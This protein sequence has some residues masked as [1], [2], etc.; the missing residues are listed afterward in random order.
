MKP[1]PAAAQAAASVSAIIS[2]WSRP[3][4]WQGPAISVSG[5]RFETPTSPI[6]TVLCSVMPLSTRPSDSRP[7][8]RCKAAWRRQG[9]RPRVPAHGRR[10]GA[11]TGGAERGDRRLPALRRRVRRHR[12]RRTRRGRCRGC[13]TRRS[14]SAGRR[15]GRGC[16][17]SG[18]RST[19]P[20]ATGCA[21]GWGWTARRSTTGGGSRCCRWRS[22]FR[23]TT[24]KAPTCRRRRSAP[25]PGG[26]GRWRRCRGVRLTLLIGGHAQRWHLGR[27]GRSP[28]RCGDWRDFGPDVIPLPHPVL[29]QHRLAEAQSVVRGGAGAGA[30]AAGRG[31]CWTA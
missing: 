13:R 29:A 25:A 4:S 1:A 26:R 28:A 17:R 12:G 23:A 7:P 10:R 27:R 14:W 9:E 8:P 18:G 6:R 16:M 5:R 31:S 22:A 24:R 2:A 11:G 19:I 20:R 30:A 15:P 3:S 21:T